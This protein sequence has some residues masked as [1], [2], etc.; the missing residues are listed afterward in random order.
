MEHVFT[1]DYPLLQ[2]YSHLDNRLGGPESLAASSKRFETSVNP[3]FGQDPTK[4]VHTK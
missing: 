1:L 3:V 4:I 2:L